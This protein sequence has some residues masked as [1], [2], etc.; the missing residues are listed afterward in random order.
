L[1]LI[2]ITQAIT[3][4]LLSRGDVNNAFYPPWCYNRLNGWLVGDLHIWLN[5][6]KL[7]ATPELKQNTVHISGFNRLAYGNQIIST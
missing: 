6:H 5:N 2:V 1:R 7:T 4:G 3:Y